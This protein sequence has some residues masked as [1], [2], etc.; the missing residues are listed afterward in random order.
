M[1][2]PEN[3][4][5]GLV[6]DDAMIR[7]ILSK[8]LSQE[9]GIEIV[10]T[11]SDGDEVLDM[12]TES[13]P[14]VLLMDVQM[15]RVNGIDAC[16]LVKEH[17]PDLPVVMLTTF[18]QAD[19]LSDAI[20]VNAQGFLTKDAEP[21]VIAGSILAA[22][23]GQPVFSPGPAKRL[24]E[25]FSDPKKA[26]LGRLDAQGLDLL[27][28]QEVVVLKLLSEAL[29]NSEIAEMLGVEESTIKSHLSAIFRK[30]G[31]RDRTEAVVYVYQNNLFPFGD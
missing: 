31:V 29:S 11:A 14:D 23:A 16:R 25:R 24:M 4:K 19:Y 22:A 2:S 1:S 20:A 12:I 13:S 17:H 15:K 5:V 21:A 30:I 7:N 28:K 9:E 18:D 6:D 3:V 26:T 8:L 10:A 27:T